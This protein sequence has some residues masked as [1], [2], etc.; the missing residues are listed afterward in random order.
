[1][2][3][4]S[5]IHIFFLLLFL[6]AYQCTYAQDYVI[7]TKG[8]SIAGTTKILN[9]GD[10]WKVQVTQA[11][12]SKSVFNVLQVKTFTNAGEPYRPVKF[13]GGF[14]FM[15]VIKNG[16]LSLLAFQRPDQT[17]FDGEYL[18]KADGNGMEVP[19]LNF[20]KA[21]SKFLIECKP[22]SKKLV[23]HVY[24]RNELAI[25]IDEYN[26]CIQN[27]SITPS[28][29][30]LNSPKP[31]LSEE[32]KSLLQTWNELSLKVKQH[33]AFEGQQD[34]T[35]MIAEVQ[36]KLNNNQRIP[37]FLSEGLMDVL[38]DT[39]LKSDLETALN[40]LPK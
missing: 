28:T 22:V 27:Q 3:S 24:G 4:F 15:K 1:M 19:N 21:M 14:T 20:K 40:G 18:L 12:K 13:N 38:K 5:I 36:D 9:F 11:D 39:D 30:S 10:Q 33:E 7:T 37:K 17:S 35:E 31:V 6:L 25:I 16:Y 23:E 26:A 8:D 29:P 32:T 2:K 34:A